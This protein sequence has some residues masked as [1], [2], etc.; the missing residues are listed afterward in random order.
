[1]RSLTLLYSVFCYLAG[2]AA[3]AFLILFLADAWVPVSV[4]RASVY[5]PELEPLSAALWNAVLLLVW[6]FQHSVMADPAFKKRWTRLIP[7][8]IERSTYVLAVSIFTFAL[9]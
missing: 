8:A 4:N 1:M 7:P 6:G 2:V 9:M 5:A 3:L